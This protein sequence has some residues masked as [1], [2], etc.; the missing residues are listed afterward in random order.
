MVIVINTVITGVRLQQTVLYNWIE[1][2]VKSKAANA[3]F[4]FDE[5]VMV[6]K[7]HSENGG[8]LA[9]TAPQRKRGGVHSDH[10]TDKADGLRRYHFDELIS[11]DR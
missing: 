9:T 10:W 7:I 6:I 2:L 11:T 1:W 4:I 8:T 3:L 5:I